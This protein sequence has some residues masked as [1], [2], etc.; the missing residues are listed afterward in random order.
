MV[1]AA[2]W[3]SR[4]PVADPFYASSAFFYHPPSYL[5]IVSRQSTFINLILSQANL[6]GALRGICGICAA[7]S[8]LSGC[9]LELGDARLLSYMTSVTSNAAL[10]F[11]SQIKTTLTCSPVTNCNSS[12]YSLPYSILPMRPCS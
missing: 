4:C 3:P 12:S 8:G 5:I 6:L 2:T 9:A 10:L 7:M 11:K 1:A